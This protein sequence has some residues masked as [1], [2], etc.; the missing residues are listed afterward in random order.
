MAGLAGFRSRASTFKGFWEGVIA[1]WL[2]FGVL[3][4]IFTGAIDDHTRLASL[5][6]GRIAKL[7]LLVVL[8]PLD[9]L[10]IDL[11]LTT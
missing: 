9:V 6:L 8:W 10:G 4:V 2:T 7:L 3:Y 11:H 1:F 5:T